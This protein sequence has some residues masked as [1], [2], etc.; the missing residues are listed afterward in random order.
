M[1]FLTEFAQRGK[2]LAE[3]LAAE[4]ARWSGLGEGSY[5]SLWALTADVPA[6]LA[7]GAQQVSTLRAKVAGELA[8][9]G[10]PD[11]AGLVEQATSTL[12]ALQRDLSDEAKVLTSIAKIPGAAAANRKDAIA[13]LDALQQAVV[14]LNAQLAGTKAENASAALLDEVAAK[15]RDAAT[16]AAAAAKAL[17]NVGGP[18]NARYVAASRYYQISIPSGPFEVRADLGR[19][20][21]QYV[22][23]TLQGMAENVETVRQVAKPEYYGPGATKLRAEAAELNDLVK[24]V[25]TTGKRALDKLVEVDPATKAVLALAQAGQMF[26]GPLATTAAL[27]KEAGALPKLTGSSLAVDIGGDNI[28]ILEAA[29]KTAVVPFDE[30]W[31]LHPQRW[32]GPE[33]EQAGGEQP[34]TFQG[35]SAIGSRILAMTSEPFATVVLTYFGGSGQAG[36]MLPRADITPEELTSL[37][38]RL[39]QAN[40]EVVEWNLADPRPA[41]TASRP[42]VLLVLPTPPPLPEALGGRGTGFGPEHAAKVA[43]AI[44]GGTPALFLTQFLWP[45]QLPFMPPASPPYGFADYLKKA[46]GID[47][48]CNF[49]VIPAVADETQ[50]GMFRL[51]PA[52]FTFVPLSTF[53]HHPIGRPLQAQRV[54]WTALAPILTTPVLPASVTVEP[55]LRVPGDWR[56]TW[57][58][59]RLADLQAQL[60]NQNATIRP[61]FQAGDIAPPFAVAVAATRSGGR[62]PVRPATAATTTAATTAPQSSPAAGAARIVAMTLGAGLVDGYLDQRV[63][64]LDARNTLVFSDPPRTNADVVINSLYW[65]VGREALISAGPVQVQPVAMIGQATMNLL[66]AIYLVGLPLAV[67]L[68]GAAVLLTRRR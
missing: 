24:E 60:E 8:G 66:R 18:E 19:F 43:A 35:D 17:K 21:E 39:T 13:K 68:G 28:V 27:L 50:P 25:T 2:E 30:V 38:K 12:S 11:Y 3:A 33:A 9:T 58:T 32:A 23:G 7:Q 61:D 47:V 57:A 63:G 44:D 62:G 65:L 16:K 46:W 59:Q 49:L 37:R 6:G 26:Q 20:V 67:G 14:E 36:R 42:Q 10:L 64:Q 40:F 1:Q 22:V 29:G 52:R 34:R 48:R 41:A 55:V 45:R 4:Q 53:T 15:A 56:G 54:L 5:L 31:P 51:A